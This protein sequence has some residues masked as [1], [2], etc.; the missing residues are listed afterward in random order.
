MNSMMSTDIFQS[1]QNTTVFQDQMPAVFECEVNGE[2]AGWRVNATPFNSLSP[3]IRGDL[4]T[5]RELSDE[6]NELLTL[7]IPGRAEYNGTTVQCI[8]GMIGVGD[9]IESDSATMKVQGM[10]MS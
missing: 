8:T 9:V 5:D 3:E 6:G 7:T 4:D 1:P 10:A 2:F